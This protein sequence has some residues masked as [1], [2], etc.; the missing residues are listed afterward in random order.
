MFSRR[1]FM[2]VF[3]APFALACASAGKAYHRASDDLGNATKLYNDDVR[4][5]YADKAAEFVDAQSRPPFVDWRTNLDKTLKLSDVHVG[6]IEFP[7]DSKEATVLVTWTFYRMSELTEQT[8]TVTEHWFQKDFR[9]FV[10]YEASAL[11]Q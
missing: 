4:W 1:K 8:K 5:G 6:T 11:P 7:K 2:I 9:W 10:R 3:A